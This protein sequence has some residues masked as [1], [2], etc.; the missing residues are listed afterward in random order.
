MVLAAVA[1]HGCG[2]LQFRRDA[3]IA[4]LDIEGSTQ[5]YDFE[6]NRITGVLSVEDGYVFRR[7]PGEAG[8][9][10]GMGAWYEY[11]DGQIVQTYRPLAPP[12]LREK[13]AAEAA[14]KEKRDRPDPTDGSDAATPSESEGR[15][16][17]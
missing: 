11:R 2:Y 15:E 4:W 13:W 14:E 16:A 17:E 10:G 6:G 3:A 8:S 1:I 7:S 9:L 5:F 12:A